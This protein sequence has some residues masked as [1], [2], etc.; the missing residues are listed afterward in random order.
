MAYW[1]ALPFRRAGELARMVVAS[2]RGNMDIYV[3]VGCFFWQNAQHFILVQQNAKSSY[4]SVAQP[5][6]IMFQ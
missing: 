1:L 3:C 5:E 6:Q 2:R 4:I